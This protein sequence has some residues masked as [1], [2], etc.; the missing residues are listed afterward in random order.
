MK[1]TLLH[2]IMILSLLLAVNMM[3]LSVNAASA[4]DSG[5]SVQP[6]S[7]TAYESLI[8]KEDVQENGETDD[9]SDGKSTISEYITEKIMP[10]AAGIVTSV[11]VFLGALW[12]IEQMLSSMKGSKELFGKAENAVNSAVENIGNSVKSEVLKVTEQIK[13]IPELEKNVAELKNE[14]EILIRECKTLAKMISI[15]FGA[16]KELVK[17]GSARK[18]QRLTERSDE[19]FSSVSQNSEES[20]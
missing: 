5:G 11:C 3:A 19:I 7:N 17:N 8:I 9:T 6:D 15:G 2:F 20:V 14:T 12:K 16:S 10:V 1:K 18:I 4:D 13:N